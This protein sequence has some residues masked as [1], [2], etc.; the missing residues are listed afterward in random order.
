MDKIFYLGAKIRNIGW[1][2]IRKVIGLRHFKR[3]WY[4][5][6]RI[7]GFDDAN[8]IIY[9]KI[10]SGKPFLAARFGD[11]ELRALVYTLDI[12]FGLKKTFPQYIKTAMHRNAGFYPADDKHLM[13]FGHLLWESSKLVDVFGV[14]YNL[15]EDYVIHET[16]PK[17]DLVELEGLEP[18]RSAMPW[19]RALKGKKVLV[20]HPFKDSIEHQ[21]AIKERLFKDSDVLPDFN[22][23]VYKAIQTN[24]GGTCEYPTWFDAL[25]KM[26]NDIQH[27]DFDIAIVGCGAY[28]LPLAAKIKAMGKQVIHLAGATQIM[29]GI[30]GARW[31]VRPEMQRFFNENWIRPSEAERP[32]NAQSVEGACY[33]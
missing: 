22:L 24:A 1:C 8:K 7:K 10:M 17:A 20:V 32:K 23:I 26:F 6:K 18:Y 21:F 5:G 15:L 30:R 3:Y 11:A 29:F 2:A 19:S 13:Q 28:G 31:D 4:Y 33:W 9:E 12:D 25:N 27:L 14:W 16:S